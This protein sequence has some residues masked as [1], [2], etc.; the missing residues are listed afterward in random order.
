MIR[1]NLSDG[2]HEASAHTAAVTAAATALTVPAAIARA[3]VL[4][5]GRS[6]AGILREN[7]STECEDNE[8]CWQKAEFHKYSQWW[9]E[10][11]P[12]R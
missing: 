8:H 12:I 4:A 6:G 3:G 10:S 11:Q 1:G 5:G 2:A 9:R 7:R